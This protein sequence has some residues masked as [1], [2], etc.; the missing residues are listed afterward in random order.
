MTV[1]DV[2]ASYTYS[3]T[4]VILEATGKQIREAIEQTATYFAWE[5]GQV[6][7]SESFLKPKAAHFNYDYFAGVNYVVDL[8]RPEGHRVTSL[9]RDG[10]ELRDDE[11][12]TVCLNNYRATGAG[13]YPMWTEAKRV[14][15][16]QREISELILEYLK[17]HDFVEI[18]ASSPFR[19]VT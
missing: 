13:E 15:E 18:P 3:N 9:T 1:R 7:I 4:L 6:T 14:R 19:T 10:R 12:F 8:T 11:V 2:V 5:D 16:I 17:E